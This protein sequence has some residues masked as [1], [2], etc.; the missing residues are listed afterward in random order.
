MILTIKP[1]VQA[2]ALNTTVLIKSKNPKMSNRAA[3]RI[4]KPGV[5]TPEPTPVEFKWITG[6]T[7][8]TISSDG[9]TYTC[10]QTNPSTGSEF[11][12]TYNGQL[13]DLTVSFD[14]NFSIASA[15]TDNTFKVVYN[16]A[17]K[18]S[19]GSST[20][21]IRVTDGTTYLNLDIPITIAVTNTV[22]VTARN[23]DVLPHGTEQ[24]DLYIFQGTEPS[25]ESALEVLRSDSQTI[26]RTYAEENTKT[27]E[28][29]AYIN[30]KSGSS[31]GSVL[32]NGLQSDG[33][34]IV[35]MV[36]RKTGKEEQYLSKSYSGLPG[37][38]EFETGGSG[39]AG[40]GP[41]ATPETADNSSAEETIVNEDINNIASEN[42]EAT[43]TVE[44]DN[45]NT[46]ENTVN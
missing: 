42:E 35:W 40:G 19:A 31:Y 21:R 33:P 7:A 9:H 46:E 44:T 17:M 20:R 22:E 6:G 45:G 38:I 36:T 15:G 37:I 41:V 28:F 32:V 29:P 43:G 13:S 25:T 30:K 3:F 10:S 16:T 11:W 39:G 2:N 34:Y 12:F 24:A 4:I 18:G 5:D 8:G 27:I 1:K 26:R 14:T 23:L